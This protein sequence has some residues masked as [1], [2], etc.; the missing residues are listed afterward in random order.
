MQ[1]EGKKRESKQESNLHQLPGSAK[2]S[3]SQ[4]TQHISPD[5]AAK[6]TYHITKC[7]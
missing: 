5:Q 6:C 1:L 7:C 2:R 4:R 3:Q